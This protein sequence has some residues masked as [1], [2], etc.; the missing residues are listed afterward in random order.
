MSPSKRSYHPLV[1]Y[2][3]HAQLLSEKNLAEIP[4]T[5]KNYWDK[6]SQE[7]MF[8]FDWVKDFGED[9]KNFQEIS[10]HKII[11]QSARICCR[12]VDCF[13][14][15]LSK[16]KGLEGLMK[17]NK[18]K[19]V[20]TI[21]WLI[22]KL[23]SPK[24]ACRIFNITSKKYYRWK[25]KI[26]CTTSKLNLCF[27]THPLQL[28]VKESTIIKDSINDPEN[29]NKPMATIYYSLLR[30]TKLFCGI[31]TFYKYANL[32]AEKSRFIIPKKSYS[33]FRASRVF[34]YLHID[35]TFMMTELGKRNIAH[36]SK[37]S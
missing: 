33:G 7:L 37:K 13:S 35:T 15:L 22:P 36:F 27:K 5:T 6:N 21:D 17:S 18:Q 25:S 32:T 34:E 29:Q 3:Y 20:D 30:S 10:K 9:Q 19:I 31:T 4:Y 2:F 23:S 8:G 1:V 11:F 28:S 24:K 16:K 14:D 12:I 26:H